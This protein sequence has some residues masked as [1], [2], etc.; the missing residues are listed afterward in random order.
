[1]F[2]HENG[3]LWAEKQGKALSWMNTYVD[4]KPVTE[5]NGYQIELNAL[6]Y[7]ALVFYSKLEHHFGAEKVANKYEE[8]ANNLK[9]NFDEIFWLNDL[10]Y[11]AD[12]VNDDGVNTDVRP[13]Q[14]IACALKYS[15]VDD[16]AKIAVFNKVKKE[17]LTSRG[18]RTLS[19]KSAKYKGVYEGNQIDR[20]LAHFNGCVM[21]WLLGVYI[22]LNYE[23]N[24]ERI[25]NRS[26]ELLNGFEE[27][28]NIHGVGSVA[29]M[30]DGNPAHKPH[31]C[32]SS[33]LSIS[34]ILRSKELLKKL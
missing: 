19:P 7:N 25:K 20:D 21:P 8:I 17:L 18:I 6:W 22:E 10:K 4:S 14:L 5:R 12:Y 13:N 9:D 3:L 26:L 24:G 33:A 30:Y 28:I 1:M 23:L 2:L 29:E 34:E 15:P 27:D 31:G 11:Y 16:L 32:I